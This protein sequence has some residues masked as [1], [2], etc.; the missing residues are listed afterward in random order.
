MIVVDIVD[1]GETDDEAVSDIETVD[2]AVMDVVADGDEDE[3]IE[4]VS[5]IGRIVADTDGESEFMALPPADAEGDGV[6]VSL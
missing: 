2:E 5:D 4:D 6:F 3:D 1:V